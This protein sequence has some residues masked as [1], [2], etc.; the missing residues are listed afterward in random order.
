MVHE[1]AQELGDFMVLLHAVRP[2]AAIKPSAEG[3]FERQVNALP[4]DIDLEAPAP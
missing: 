3:G 4:L 2:D 1:V